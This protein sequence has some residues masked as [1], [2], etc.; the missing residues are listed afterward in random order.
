MSGARGELGDDLMMAATNSLDQQ[1]QRG[2]DE[3]QDSRSRTLSS[4]RWSEADEKV[5]ADQ[6]EPKMRAAGREDPGLTG[7]KGRA[8]AS[9]QKCF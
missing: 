2:E 8:S 7:R 3:G 6:K 9:D 5:D 1:D 4:R